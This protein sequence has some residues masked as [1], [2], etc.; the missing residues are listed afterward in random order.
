MR[1][2]EDQY[3]NPTYVKD[4]A[5]ML[6]ILLENKEVGVFNL[7]GAP[8][9]SRLEYIEQILH[10]ANLDNPVGRFLRI[11]LAGLPRFQITN[12]HDLYV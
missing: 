3:G 12:A 10:C 6:A 5:A 11:V 4:F 2:N 9:V 1:A 7:I 8:I